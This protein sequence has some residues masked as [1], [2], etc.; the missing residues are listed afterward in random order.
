MPMAAFQG[1]HGHDDEGGADAPAHRMTPARVYM[2]WH[3]MQVGG[4]CRG[5]RMLQIPRTHPPRC[6]AGRTPR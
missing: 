3:S 1:S 4:A 6:R 5:A 2:A